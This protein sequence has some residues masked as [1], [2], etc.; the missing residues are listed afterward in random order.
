MWKILHPIR[1]AKETNNGTQKAF[2]IC[3]RIQTNAIS[4]CQWPPSCICYHSPRGIGQYRTLHP[5]P[6]PLPQLLPGTAPS[7]LNIFW[8]SNIAILKVQIGF[9][10]ILYNVASSYVSVICF[11]CVTETISFLKLWQHLEWCLLLN[12]LF[13]FFYYKSFFACYCASII[14]VKICWH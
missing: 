9:F 5:P 10:I 7:I 12:K 11:L 13:Q 2:L 14:R 6:H 3:S 8:C 4:A 1:G